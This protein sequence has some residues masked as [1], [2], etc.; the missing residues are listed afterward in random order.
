MEFKQAFVSLNRPAEVFN[1]I[2]DTLSEQPN[3]Q[4]FV[5]NKLYDRIRGRFYN[6]NIISGFHYYSDPRDNYTLVDWFY[7]IDIK[8]NHE[9]HVSFVANTEEYM[10]VVNFSSPKVKNYTH[11]MVGFKQLLLILVKTEEEKTEK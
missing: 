2:E 9:Y 11:Y 3:T 6:P 10:Q 4:I 8:N 1:V 5:A 7:K